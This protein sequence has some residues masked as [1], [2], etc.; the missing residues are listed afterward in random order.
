MWAAWWR[1]G[2][3]TPRRRG[4]SRVWS[5]GKIRI[6]ANNIWYAYLYIKYLEQ[7][8]FR[9]QLVYGLESEVRCVGEAADGEEM[10]VAVTDPGHLQRDIS[11]LLDISDGMLIER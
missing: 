6:V 3:R 10:E 2:T 5:E 1:S 4:G 11:G 9:E 8:V 7:I